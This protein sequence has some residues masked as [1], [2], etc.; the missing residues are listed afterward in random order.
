MTLCYNH[1]LLSCGLSPLHVVGS[2]DV[3]LHVVPCVWWVNTV[4]EEPECRPLLCPYSS[5][6]SVLQSTDSD[7]CYSWPSRSHDICVR[8][9]KCHNP[10]PF[11]FPL[12]FHPLFAFPII[13]AATVMQGQPLPCTIPHI[14]FS[15]QWSACA[16]AAV[17]EDCDHW[18]VFHA[19]S[20]QEDGG[21]GGGHHAGGCPS[22][23][24]QDCP[25]AQE[26]SA[27]PY[28]PRHRALPG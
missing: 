12:H 24:H 23:L 25:A 21:D 6:L 10:L 20:D 3:L 18:A 5:S 4:R 1:P 7:G 8:K 16:G 19:A 14:H 9:G 22:Q 28:G 11:S 13:T 2:Q 15:Q 27:H 17:G 26:G